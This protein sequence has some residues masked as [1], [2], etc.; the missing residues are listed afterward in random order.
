[1]CGMSASSATKHARGNLTLAAAREWGRD[2]L[3]L[4]SHAAGLAAGMVHVHTVLDVRRAMHARCPPQVLPKTWGD[5]LWATTWP[6]K[7]REV[8][9]QSP[10]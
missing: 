9:S 4:E 6:H 10:P 1:M 2:L 8:R 3:D 5:D 7:E